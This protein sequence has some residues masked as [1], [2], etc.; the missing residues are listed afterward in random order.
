MY[1]VIVYEI[2][3]NTHMKHVQHLC[4]LD[5]LYDSFY[6]CHDFDLITIGL[7]VYVEMGSNKGTFFA[8]KT[9]SRDKEFEPRNRVF[10][11]LPPRPRSCLWVTDPDHC[12]DL[13]LGLKLRHING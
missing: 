7:N 2:Q 3:A 5:S 4:S 1:R 13:Q 9:H 10:P 6:M 11:S 12:N 8:H